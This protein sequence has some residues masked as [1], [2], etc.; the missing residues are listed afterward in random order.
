LWKTLLCPVFAFFAR[1]RRV[2]FTRDTANPVPQSRRGQCIGK[3]GLFV[4]QGDIFCN[5]AAPS[6]PKSER[7]RQLWKWLA[8]LLLDRL[9]HALRQTSFQYFG[10]AFIAKRGAETRL[11]SR[12]SR[13]K[14]GQSPRVCFPALLDKIRRSV[15]FP[16]H[17]SEGDVQGRL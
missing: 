17:R 14:F 2:L 9:V 15:H 1:G 12:H 4:R 8:P 10:Q 5:A 3:H 16:P 11:S 7:S 6:F 13:K